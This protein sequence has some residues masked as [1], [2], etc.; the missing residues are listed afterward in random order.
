MHNS[1]RGAYHRMLIRFYLEVLASGALYR[2]EFL[3]NV[4]F[5]LTT[6]ESYEA[7]GVNTAPPSIPRKGV[8][9]SGPLYLFCAPVS[10]E[11]S[12]THFRYVILSLY[13][14]RSITLPAQLPTSRLRATHSERVPNASEDQISIEV[15]D[16][17]AMEASL[18]RD[19]MYRNFFD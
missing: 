15:L 12:T 9:C 17:R 11:A 18:I 7:S 3:T 1:A 4:V 14:L 13:P 19:L 2:G 16:L 8:Q 10:T 5:L 6:S